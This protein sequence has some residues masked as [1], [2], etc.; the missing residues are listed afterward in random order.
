[1]LKDFDRRDLPR[2]RRKEMIQ[3]K[4]GQMRMEWQ[5]WDKKDC[6]QLGVKPTE[7]YGLSTGMTTD[8]TG[9]QREG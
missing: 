7:M 9:A 3:R 5:V 2:R 6:L 1:M 4:F 8:A